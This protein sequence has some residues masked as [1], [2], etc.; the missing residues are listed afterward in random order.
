M[1]E[2]VTHYESLIKEIVGLT[3]EFKKHD[4]TQSQLAYIYHL[5]SQLKTS[6][7]LKSLTQEN[8]SED[9]IYS[10][11]NSM[12]KDYDS[13]LRSNKVSPS[14]IFDDLKNKLF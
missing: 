5:T 2:L 4:L 6:L 7:N 9:A 12:L 11:W 1:K 3:S 14:Q 10:T 13:R 8:V